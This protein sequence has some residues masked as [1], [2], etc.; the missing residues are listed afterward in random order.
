MPRA[1]RRGCARPSTAPLP[2]PRTS[3][4]RWL[5][6]FVRTR[7]LAKE[8]PAEAGK[9]L[10]AELDRYVEELEEHVL[11]ALE[12]RLAARM[13]ELDR[14]IDERLKTTTDVLANQATSRLR[15]LSDELRSLLERWTTERGQGLEALS[16]T[17]GD[18]FET[19]LRALE[20]GQRPAGERRR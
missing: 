3:S 1:S 13:Q 4:R 11:A 2:K 7:D 8:E 18:E 12:Q 9:D 15:E 5:T 6:I 14:N 17:L 16:R 19:R 20:K 10:A